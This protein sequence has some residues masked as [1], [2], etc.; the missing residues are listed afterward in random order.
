MRKQLKTRKEAKPQA[1]WLRALALAVLPFVFAGQTDAL[2][3]APAATALPQNPNVV[4]G[5]ITVGTSGATMNVTQSS[6]KAIINWG[7]FD[8]G[9]GATVNFIQPGA[10]ATALNRVMSS[11]PSQIYGTLTATG[12]I[13]IINPNG[14]VFGSGARVD[15]ADMVAS[16]M[17]ISDADFLAGSDRFTRDGATGSIVNNGAINAREGGYVALIGA[18]VDNAGTINTPSGKA[19]LAAGETVQLPLTDSGLITLN[20]NPATIETSVSNEGVIAAPDGQVYISAAAANNLASSVVNKGAISGDTVQMAATNGSLFVEKSSSVTARQISASADSLTGMGDFKASGTGASV[21]LNGDYVSLGGTISADNAAAKGG[22]VR[23]NGQSAVLLGTN[24]KVSANGTQGGDVRVTAD[25][26]FLLASGKIQATG[27]N[28]TGG[29]IELAGAAS[30]TLLGAEIDAS[31]TAGGGIIHIGGGWHGDTTGLI[32]GPLPVSSTVSVD[33]ATTLKADALLSGLGG[34]VVVWS[35]YSTSFYGAASARGGTLSGNGGAIELSSGGTL[36]V[37]LASDHGLNALARAAGYANG[38]IVIDPA[39]IVIGDALG[40]FDIFQTLLSGNGT[41]T[42]PDASSGYIVS[43]TNDYALIGPTS[44]SLPTHIGAYLYNLITGTWTDLATVPNQ[45]ITALPVNSYFGAS[46]ALNNEYA[47]I[48]A[49][50]VSSNRGD[51][52]LY[53][54]STGVWTAL[55]GT[56]GQPVTGLSTARFGY[57][58]ALN[59]TYALI[60]AYGVSSLRGEAYLYNISEQTWTVLSETPNQMVT[61]LPSNSYF[62]YT[63]ALNDDYALINAERVSAYRGNVFLYKLDDN[64]WTDLAATPLSPVPTLASNAYFGTALALN[65]T[66]ALIGAYGASSD[67]GDAYLYNLSTGEWTDIAISSPE[68]AAFTSI[69]YGHFGLSVALNENYMLIGAPTSSRWAGNGGD[70]FLYNF[71]TETWTDLSSTSGAPL[72]SIGT[73]GQLGNSV[74][75]NDQTALMLGMGTARYTYTLATGAWTNLN[76]PVPTNGTSSI[77]GIYDLALNGTYALIG[78]AGSRSA[79]LY[80]FLTG[81]WRDLAATPGQP[82][83]S[84]SLS[85]NFGYGVALNDLYALIGAPLAYSGRGDA[86]LYNL[87]TGVW[88]D[89]ATTSGQS[90]SDLPA[91]SNFGTSVALSGTHALIGAQ[92]INSNQGDAYLY[93]LTTGDWLSLS[94]TGGNP[95]TSLSSN[96]YFG[97][98]VALNSRY[99]LIGAYGVLA[100]RGDAYLYDLSN[101]S[102]TDLAETADQPITVLSGGTYF[103]SSVALNSTYALIGARSA[104]DNVG[105]AYLY[106]LSDGAWT[107]LTATPGELISSLS[108]PWAYFGVDVALDDTYALIG[109]STAG[110]TPVY[111]LGNAFLYNLTTGDWIDLSTTSGQPVSSLDSTNLGFGFHVAL[112]GGYAL[113][114]LQVGTKLFLYNIT[115]DNWTTLVGT[116]PKTTIASNASFGTSVTIND[117][118]A[119]IGSPGYS[120]N[121]GDAYLYNLSTGIWTDL[122]VTGFVISGLGAGSKFG[123]SVAL[124][125]SYALIGVPGISSSRGDAFLY[126]IATGVWTKLSS[127]TL[128]PVT[129]LGGSSFFGASVAL[130]DDYALIGAYGVSASRGDAYLYDLSSG[131]W[132]TLS[133]TAL[134]PVTALAGGSKFGVSVALNDDY[135]LIGASGYSSSRGNAYFYRLTDGDWLSLSSTIN[136]PVSML[137]TNSYFGYSVALNGSYALIGAY[138]DSSSRGDGYLYNISTGE[139]TDGWT[140]LSGTSDAPVSGLSNN[141]YFGYSVALSET[142]ALIGAYGAA[143]GRGDAYL[144]NLSASNW[145]DLATLGGAA[146]STLATAANFGKSVAI[147]ASYALIG[148]PGVSTNR[149][150]AYLLPL[151]N[152]E[153]QLNTI[154]SAT[155]Q[156]ALTGGNVILAADNS[157]LIS[158]LV[159]TS[160]NPGNSLTL[161]SGGSF[162]I[163]GPAV[164]GGR[165]ALFLA[166]A[167]NAQLGNPALRQNGAG[168]MT[169]AA[170]AFVDNTGGDLTLRIGTAADT[171]RAGAAALAGDFTLGGALTAS[172]I[173]IDGADSAINLSALLTASA[174]GTAATLNGESISLAGAGSFVTANGRW[175]VYNTDGGA[176]GTV[177]LNGLVRGFN[178]Y[179]C[180]L[181][182][183][184]STGATLPANGNGVIYAYAPTVTISGLDTVTK[185]YDG[186]DTVNVSGASLNGFANGDTATLSGTYADTNVANGI[187]LTYALNTAYGYVLSGA[188][189]TGDITP[190]GL[191]ITGLSANNKT[192]D[193]TTAATV[194][195]GGASLSGVIGSDDVTLNLAGLVADFLNAAVGNNKPISVSGAALGGSDAGNY[196]LSQ[197]AG[198]TAN[199]LEVGAP[200]EP[201]APSTTGSSQSGLLLPHLVSENI[202]GAAQSFGLAYAA[203]PTETAFLLNGGSSNEAES[204][205]ASTLLPS[206]GSPAGMDTLLVLSLPSHFE[207]GLDLSGVARTYVPDFA[208]LIALHGVDETP[209]PQTLS[210]DL[211]TGRLISQKIDQ[212]YNL[213]LEIET[214]SGKTRRLM[215]ML[216]PQRAEMMR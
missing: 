185:I 41:I 152:I 153:R 50:G 68:A 36:N 5:D 67:C 53:N 58:V 173:L 1:A 180:T 72:S 62:G 95:I 203:R 37:Q 115:G 74:A 33:T 12:K 65:K 87:S 11:D 10:T 171:G 145:T 154:T 44:S 138:G 6:S 128:Q 7:R 51:A 149:G 140:K 124:N 102:W 118:Y 131:D 28:G 143:S 155:I 77:T 197:P 127:T 157:F 204:G 190:K 64:T 35:S 83:T 169:I 66:Y 21:T 214:A 114:S 162:D 211:A 163:E 45:P 168:S 105:D 89:L 103:G 76:P 55:S 85:S 158:R 170:G 205:P 191:T 150:Q 146:V 40:S 189:A 178:R 139:V 80:N 142:F 175:L 179:G 54:L 207:D 198:L 2:A 110:K 47:L 136:A 82:V 144:Y 137:S 188:A 32:F 24:S 174:N 165:T 99:A 71:A 172:T 199:I 63:V 156:T 18:K 88:T 29:Q 39:D 164:L 56:P 15:A 206:W 49:Y 98:N 9:S 120:S 200:V 22:S 104:N 31:G 79:L 183:G 38:S 126:D 91:N 78:S 94:S 132:T 113:V 34:E 187:G 111:Q 75:L 148:A 8:I 86:Y 151:A 159:L 177:G 193:G 57:S 186:A 106:K 16:T 182:G 90:I 17:N 108:W 216:A 42:A 27:S 70:V 84:L 196:S 122:A 116:S 43:M 125:E 112:G 166:N 134:Q 97:Y 92:G 117:Y 59:D 100:N 184:C 202:F 96:S 213:V 133:G 121:R 130:N 13:Y 61:A 147:G 14:V 109:A 208:K 161:I 107:D 201:P 81:E 52:Y 209:L 129:A 135:A 73:Y 48:G 101:G 23:I 212:P 167:A 3:D 215:V 69:N 119:L 26:G 176:L 20:V 25:S 93:N 30:T 123:S 19:I 181:A 210:L 194:N 192:F 141:A 4:A 46:V 160:A 195:I 60:G